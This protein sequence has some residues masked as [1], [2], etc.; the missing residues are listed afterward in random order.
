MLEGLLSAPVRGVKD[1]NVLFLLLLL[2]FFF[3]SLSRLRLTPAPHGCRA[4][5]KLR[6]IWR[7][8]TR[9]L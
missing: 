4:E 1:S 2:S 7:R 3:F 6:I 8:D 9:V 5:N